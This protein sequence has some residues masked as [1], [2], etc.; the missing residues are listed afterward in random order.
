MRYN[1]KCIPN[2]TREILTIHSKYKLHT[3]RR[4]Y[5]YTQLNT[6]PFTKA[7]IANTEVKE[8]AVSD[9]IKLPVSG[10]V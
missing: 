1:L 5:A 4:K 6:H 9:V 2:L 3:Q 8:T 7:D 10:S